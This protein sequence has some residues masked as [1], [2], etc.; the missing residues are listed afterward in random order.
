LVQ[1]LGQVK[2]AQ[3]NPVLTFVAAGVPKEIELN[4]ETNPVVD[5]AAM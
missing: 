3:A 2:D 4:S 5:P 1:K